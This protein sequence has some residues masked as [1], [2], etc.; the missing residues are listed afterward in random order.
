MVGAYTI[1]LLQYVGW[2]AIVVGAFAMSVTV[3]LGMDRAAFR[4][5]RGASPTTLL[6]TSFA[7]SYFLQSLVFVSAGARAQ[8]VENLPV[9]VGEQVDLAG[10]RIGM[11]SILT[12]TTAAVLLGGLAAFLTKTGLG[13]Q[14][15]AAAE[16]FEMARLLGVRANVV[17][18]AAFAISGVLAG[19]VSLLWVFQTATVSPRMGLLPV[20][21]GFVATIIGGLGSLVGA[22]LGGLLLGCLTV[23][24]QASL[25]LELRGAR[26]A[27][28]FAGVIAV[29]VL[30]PYGLLGSRAQAER[31]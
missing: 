25:P 18:G 13:I 19:A 26:D 9:F 21:I 7:I 31:V 11:V 10:F 5:I 27:F 24:L 8:A 6:I 29:L 20:L 12:A 16:D 15:R 14:M 2:A 28:V 17:I 1:L 3:A 22:A 4:P 23:A 30:R